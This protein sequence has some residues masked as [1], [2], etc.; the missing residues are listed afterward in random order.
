MGDRTEPQRVS[1]RARI[2]RF[3]GPALGLLA[4]VVIPSGAGGLGS[5]GRATVAVA[6]IMATWWVTEALPIAATALLPIVL[7]PLTGVLGIEDATAPYANDLI[8]LFMGGFMIALAMQRWGLHRRIALVTVRAVGT[9]PVRLIGGFMLA[10]AFLSMWV[11]NTAT[12]VMMLPIGVSV[13]QLVFDRLDQDTSEGSLTGRGA[14][15]FATCLM[16]AI[17]YA[18]SIGSLATIIGTPPNT[19][20]VAFL[21][22]EAGVSIGFGQWMLFGLPLAAVFL[23]IGWVML[24]RVLYPPEIDEVPGGREM[25]QRELDEIGPVSRGEKT[26]GVVFAVTALLWIFRSPIS[27]SSLIASFWPSIRFLDD[28]SIA[29]GAAIA[30][31]LIPVDRRH[32]AFAL[33]WRTAVQLPWGV[34]LLFGGGLSLAAAVTETG[35]DVYIGE[36]VGALG[37]LPTLLLVVLV[38]TLV[39]FL[40]EFTSNTATTAA[41]VPI[42]AGVAGGLGYGPV[43]LVVPAALAATCAFMLPVATPP[44]AIVFGSGHITIPQMVRAGIWLNLVAIVMVTL[45]MYALGF[46]VLGA[47][48]S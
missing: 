39:I 45:A 31:F 5:S 18:A 38:V 37:G 44:N 19:F 48:L 30:L 14:T 23:V 16:L 29:I 47:E 7:F 43:V 3:L 40:T 35:V 27:G 42:M 21:Q 12:T 34:L 26:V 6:V 11:S 4:Y 20:V 28:A 17:A 33:D 32:G 13:L 25:I 24:T 8:F 15:R 2:G 1:Q 10:T 41:V 9:S 22:Q 36:Q 46:T